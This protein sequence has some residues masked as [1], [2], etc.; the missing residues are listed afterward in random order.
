MSL[1]RRIA[2]TAAAAVAVAVALGSVVAYLVVR[3]T[4]RG[5]IDG[6]L[7]RVPAP[8]FGERLAVRLPPGV[9]P[10]ADP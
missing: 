1:R 2:V 6:S 9:E 10:A 8:A 7:R 5:Q 3:D 4:L